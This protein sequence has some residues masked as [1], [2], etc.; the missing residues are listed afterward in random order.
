M[1]RGIINNN[2]FTPVLK[3]QENRIIICILETLHDT[4]VKHYHKNMRVKRIHS[5]LDTH[6]LYGNIAKC[7]I[8]FYLK[9][10]GI[11]QKRDFLTVF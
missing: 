4:E 5:T 2:S 7:N 9:N 8:I 6:D 11:M 1:G 10:A 3:L